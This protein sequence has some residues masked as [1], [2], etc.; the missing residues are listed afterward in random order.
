[1]HVSDSSRLHALIL[2]VLVLS[3][4]IL[5]TFAVT[6]ALVLL[7]LQWWFN[8]PLG[9]TS[10]LSLAII[11]GLVIWLFVAVFH[12]KS[13]S[14]RLAFDDRPTFQQMLG[15]QLSE[16]GYEVVEQTVDVLVSRPTFKAY[17]LGG[18]IRVAFGD[19]SADV[20]GPKLFVE[21]LR[22]RLRLDHHV[23]KVQ[24]T[25][26][27]GDINLNRAHKRVQIALRIV[28]RQWPS[29]DREILDNL[30]MA[31]AEV[32]CDV[33]ILAKCDQGIPE[34]LLEHHIRNWLKREHICARIIKDPAQWDDARWDGARLG[35]DDTEIN[36]KVE[37]SV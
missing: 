8:I 33:E 29:V 17:L 7:P 21:I 35:L 2:R 32:I 9:S 13:D 12:I 16:L 20:T 5:A 28:G 26:S 23:T 34:S 1:M 4:T 22:K 15:E 30:T 24:Q 36:A 6:V 37:S 14:V 11:C 10:G 3:L 31:G 18:Q 27:N 19:L 25:L